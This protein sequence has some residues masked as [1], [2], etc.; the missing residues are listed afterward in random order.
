MSRLSL[1]YEK[2]RPDALDSLSTSWNNTLGKSRTSRVSTSF[3]DLHVPHKSSLGWRPWSRVETGFVTNFTT[4][5]SFDRTYSR[6]YTRPYSRPYNVDPIVPV[7]SYSTSYSGQSSSRYNTT[8]TSQEVPYRPNRDYKS[9]LGA[10]YRVRSYQRRVRIL[11]PPPYFSQPLVRLLVL[12]VRPA[13]FSPDS[14]LVVNRSSARSQLENL[15]VMSL[16]IV[17]DLGGLNSKTGRV[18][19]TAAAVHSLSALQSSNQLP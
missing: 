18:L 1:S 9:H 14:R 16:A 7:A 6:Q 3:S 12:A 17:Y 8:G 2:R 5:D 19:L 10:S 11:L 15:F 4:A 13:T